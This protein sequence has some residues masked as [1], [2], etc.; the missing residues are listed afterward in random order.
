MKL[1]VKFDI[2]TLCRKVL[3]QQLK[4]HGLRYRLLSFGEVE[5]YESLNQDQHRIFQ[6]KLADYGIEVIENQKIALV[7]KIKAAIVQLVFSDEII[8][9]KASVYLSEKLDHSYG[10]LSNLFS[11]I[12]CT[13]IENFIILQK[14]EYTKELIVRGKQNLTEIARKLNYSSVAHLSS[15]FKNTTGLTPSQFQKIMSKRRR[16]ESAA[17]HKIS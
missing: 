14:I 8:P 11:E 1:Y 7:Q 10:Y 16:L 6:N 2:N 4:E 17:N 5:L 9:V 12:A 15:Q 13:S 3:D